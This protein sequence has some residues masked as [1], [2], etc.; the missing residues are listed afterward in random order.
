MKVCSRGGRARRGWRQ[1]DGARR[2][3]AVAGPFLRRRK[4]G[5]PRSPAWPAFRLSWLATRAPASARYRPNR[6]CR[7][8][9]RRF[10]ASTVPTS[11]RVTD[12]SIRTKRNASPGASAA[13]PLRRKREGHARGA[14]GANTQKIVNTFN[15]AATKIHTKAS[16]LCT[17]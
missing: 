9:P 14:A 5:T 16:W 1:P 6:Q 11:R 17:S 2:Q 15:R 4:D 3:K 7:K 8:M 12:P 10:A 13:R